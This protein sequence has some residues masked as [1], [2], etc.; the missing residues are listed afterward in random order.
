MRE[1]GV[2]EIG[3]T[4]VS[5]GGRGETRGKKETTGGGREEMAS[6][7]RFRGGL[8][9]ASVIP[10]RIRSFLWNPAESSGIIFGRESYQNCHSKD[11]L[12]RR[13]RA[14]LELGLEWS[15]NGP[16][17]NPVECCLH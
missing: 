1:G 17:R 5:G 3:G 11:H 12:F 4:V 15:R 9:H 2:Q 7:G 13:N 6:R 8:Y 10:A 16:E 14:I